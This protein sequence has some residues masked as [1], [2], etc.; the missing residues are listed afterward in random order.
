[1]SE[2]LYKRD[3]SL[4]SIIVRKTTRE[5][6]R[7]IA[8][9]QQTYDSIIHGLIRL[10]EKPETSWACLPIRKSNLS[11]IIIIPSY[12]FSKTTQM[13]YYNGKIKLLELTR[14]PADADADAGPTKG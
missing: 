6:L 4:T 14:P 8:H 13:Y 5:H 1:M 7:T 2:L 10:K 12:N 11:L 9:K 3:K